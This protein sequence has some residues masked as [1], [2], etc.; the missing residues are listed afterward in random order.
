MDT[1]QLVNTETGERLTISAANKLLSGKTII[2]E[3]TTDVALAHW[4]LARCV[5]VE[6]PGDD[7]RLSDTA[8]QG[9][10]GVWRQVW[11]P[12]NED[13]EQARASAVTRINAHFQQ[14]ATAAAGEYPD[15]E[16][17]TWADQEAEAL[18]YQSW[19]AAGSAPAS[20]PACTVLTA[21]AT[22][23]GITVAGLASRVIANAAA[24]RTAAATLAGQRQAAID[25]IAAAETVAE[26][27]A[28]LDGL[29]AE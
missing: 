13:I 1:M 17:A 20:Q 28:V 9:A 21:I 22:A 4:G 29:S 11:E 15:F 6:R 27:T 8:E 5:E 3:S 10:D 25:S 14:L 18:A 16:M 7:Y 19:T 2:T 26:I 24:W 23:R 12:V